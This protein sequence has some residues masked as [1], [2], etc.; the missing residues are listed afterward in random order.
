MKGYQEQE[1]PDETKVGKDLWKQLKRVSIPV[2]NRDKRHYD[3]NYQITKFMN[4]NTL[5][6]RGR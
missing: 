3:N 1:Q 6:F 4:F 5:H 2:F